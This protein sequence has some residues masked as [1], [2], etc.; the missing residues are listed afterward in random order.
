[1]YGNKQ[2]ESGAQPVVMTLKMKPN[3]TKIK[4]HLMDEK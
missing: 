4:I 2:I 1:M 3:K